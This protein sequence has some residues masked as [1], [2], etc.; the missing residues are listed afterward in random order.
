MLNAR[1]NNTRLVFLIMKRAYTYRERERKRKRER[2]RME[3][4]KHGACTHVDE[5]PR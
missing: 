3:I 1:S 5:I 2:K 4:I